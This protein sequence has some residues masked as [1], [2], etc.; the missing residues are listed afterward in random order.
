MR[1]F[2]NIVITTVLFFQITEAQKKNQPT[3]LSLKDFLKDFYD[4]SSLPAYASKTYSAEFSTYDRTGLNNDGFEG[5]YSFIKR[6]ADSSLVIFDVTG[7]GVINRFWTPTPSDDSLDFYIDDSSKISFTICYRDLFSGK[8]YPFVTPLCSNQLGGYYSYLPIPFSKSCKI[9][10][11]GKKEKFHQ[12]GYRLYPA[13]TKIEKFSLHLNNDEQQALSILKSKF[14]KDS[15]L[16]NDIYADGTNI[17]TNN[18][19]VILHPGESETVFETKQEG[20]IL[21]FDFFADNDLEKIAKDIDL[22]ITWDDENSPAVY[23]PLADYFGYAFGKPSMKSLLIGSDGKKHYCYLPMPFDKSAKIEL[24]YRRNEKEMNTSAISVHCNIYVNDKKRDAEKEGKFYTYWIRNNPVQIHQ[25]HIM[26]DVK[27]KGHF[28]GTVLQAQG[29]KPGMTLFFEGDDSTVVDGELR[30]HGTGSEDFFN[31]GWYALL[32]TWDGAMSLPL[33]GALAYSL[34]L[35]HTGGYRF[36]IG[37]KI[38]FEKSLFQ[39]IEHGPSH[40]EI[41]ADYTSVSYYYCSQPN[42]QTIYPTAENTRLHESD[43]LILYPQLLNAAFDGDVGIETKWAF[44]TGGLTFYYTVKENTI[45]R[46]SFNEIPSGNY[47]MYLDYV[48]SPESCKFSV[49][50]RQTQLTDWFDGHSDLVTQFDMQ[51]ISDFVVSP[52]SNTVSLRFKPNGNQNKFIL[53]RIVLIRKQ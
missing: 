18:K 24:V 37:D 20:R 7:A 38:S 12:I 33:S 5:T 21:G 17:S 14:E 51:N 45:I 41:P 9:I 32:D 22:K 43:T 15:L 46:I 27:G 53:N 3:H 48:K 31:G 52:I 50:K 44:P 36:F 8:V 28:I 29:L 10:F 1:Q 42:A 4:I 13:G 47:R 25:P 23:C 2:F 30:M 6:N 40:N 11:R 26:L 49:W 35:C 19:N 34:P 16:V 39:S